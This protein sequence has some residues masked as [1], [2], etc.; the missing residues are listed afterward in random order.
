MRAPNLVT[1]HYPIV[2]LGDFFRHMAPVPSPICHM[3]TQQLRFFTNF[4]KFSSFSHGAHLLWSPPPTWGCHRPPQ[5]TGH[6][7]HPPAGLVP[8]SGPLPI[9]FY[10]S[11]TQSILSGSGKP[12]IGPL[13][14]VCAPCA[15]PSIHPS[16]HPS[17]SLVQF[18]L[19]PI[20]SS[21]LLSP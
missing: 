8:L 18:S 14:P 13:L 16:F 10:R 1:N 15:P 5:S 11:H 12:P 4:I 21:V 7:S 2:H 19:P 6:P 3:F 20:P 17:T 9:D